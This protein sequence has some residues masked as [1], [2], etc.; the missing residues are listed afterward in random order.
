V[1]RAGEQQHPPDG[2]VGVT[3]LAGDL[4]ER[5]QFI[6]GQGVRS[7]FALADDPPRFKAING[8]SL[9]PIGFLI[10][11]P[12]KKAADAS[13]EIV[14]LVGGAARDRLDNL[15]D[16]ARGDLGDRAPAQD[17]DELTLE[18]ARNLC[19]LAFSGEFI[20]SEIFYYRGERGGMLALFGKALA[21]DLD[22]GINAAR[23]KL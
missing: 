11:S 13:K 22:C 21:L 20:A 7:R 16:V 4:P 3:H 18:I 23:D 19:T 12:T 8:G 15:D 9:D 2:A 1:A 6:V 5:S 14:G 17:R 10:D